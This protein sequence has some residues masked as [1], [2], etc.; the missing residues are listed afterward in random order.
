MRKFQITVKEI[1]NEHMPECPSDVHFREDIHIHINLDSPDISNVQT[2]HLKNIIEFI[3]NFKLKKVKVYFSAE[4]PPQ[5]EY[6]IG[7][8]SQLKIA[9]EIMPLAPQEESVQKNGGR[10]RYMEINQQ[11]ENEVER[12]KEEVQALKEELAATINQRDRLL[13]EN[14]EFQSL[15]I[16]SES[17]A[18]NPIVLPGIPPYH[19]GDSNWSPAM[20]QPLADLSN[21]SEQQPPFDFDLAG[22]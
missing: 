13:R 19:Q 2:R 16:A 17:Q 22:N 4:V 11:L 20:F 3:K 8:L 9:S 5:F 15:L 14:Q 10:P 7:E 12:L 21:D 6:L 18:S 1:I